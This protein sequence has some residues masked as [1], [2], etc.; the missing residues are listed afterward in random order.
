MINFNY[1]IDLTDINVIFESISVFF[2][3]FVFYTG[4]NLYK[5]Y[6]VQGKSHDP[7]I[8]MIIYMI[9]RSV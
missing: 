7:D 8:I 4:V 5:N 2:D 1:S 6:F 3:Q 9:Y